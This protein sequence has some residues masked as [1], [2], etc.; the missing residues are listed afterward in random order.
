MDR[1]TYVVLAVASVLTAI[2]LQ[3]LGNRAWWVVP[4]LLFVFGVAMTWRPMGLRSVLVSA[5]IAVVSGAV[6]KLLA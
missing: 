5:S 2:A 4:P 1:R 3:W 6:L